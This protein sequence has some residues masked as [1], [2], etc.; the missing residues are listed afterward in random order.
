[1]TMPEVSCKTCYA[2]QLSIAQLHLSH[3]PLQTCGGEDILYIYFNISWALSYGPHYKSLSGGPMATPC[4]N[5]WIV[6]KINKSFNHSEF[7]PLQEKTGNVGKQ[8]HI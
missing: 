4:I 5:D 1:M 8:V 7:Y 6:E 3:P 2:E